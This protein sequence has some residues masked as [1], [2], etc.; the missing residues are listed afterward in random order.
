MHKIF[1]FLENLKTTLGFTSKFRKDRVIQNTSIFLFGPRC[2][3]QFCYH[4]AG[5]ARVG[6]F[7]LIV[8]MC[9]YLSVMAVD[10]VATRSCRGPSKSAL[11][12]VKDQTILT[13]NGAKHCLYYSWLTKLYALKYHG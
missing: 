5:E 12:N 10:V 2:P 7:N 9:A 6:C 13:N 1:F 4:L 8:F 3:F 11:C